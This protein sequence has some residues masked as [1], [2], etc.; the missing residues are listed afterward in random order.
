MCNEVRN[1]MYWNSF[2]S[3]F[4]KHNRDV[5]G[6][7]YAP[8]MLMILLFYTN[9]L[10]LHNY[11]TFHQQNVAHDRKCVQYYS[12]RCVVIQFTDCDIGRGRATEELCDKTL[13]NHMFQPFKKCHSLGL[14]TVMLSKTHS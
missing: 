14:E 13:P 11:L 7:N 6:N 5:L 4:K 12:A 10:L 2:N 3:L 8:N 1:D 9:H